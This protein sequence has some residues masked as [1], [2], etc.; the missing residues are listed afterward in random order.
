MPMQ[1]KSGPMLHYKK[2]I[3]K[4]DWRREYVVL[5]DNSALVWLKIEKDK[6]EP[7]GSLMLK[8]A[9]EL[10]ACGPFT[11]Q[12][13]NRPEIPEGY[14]VSQL[15]AFGSR[16]DESVHWFLC[17][18]SEDVLAW[19]TAINNTLPPPPPPRIDEK[20]KTISQSEKY[21]EED[22]F[23][24]GML[25]AT[26]LGTG[27]GSGWGWDDHVSA[28]DHMSSISDGM[29]SDGY[30]VNIFDGDGCDFDVCAFAF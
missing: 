15:L 14:K 26:I 28:S 11:I 9:P 19:I 20:N 5:Y 6:L 24:C 7:E 3:F 12:V 23:T 8:D 13:P 30:D 25:T 17:K 1:M 22:A 29:Q 27:W 16:K 18:N 2:R 21:N 10:V 4:K